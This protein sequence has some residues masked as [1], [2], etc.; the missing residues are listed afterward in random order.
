MAFCTKCGAQNVEGAVHCS[1][2]G[3][4]I[5]GVVAPPQTA[6]APAAPAAPQVTYAPAV[7]AVPVAPNFFA[8][9]WA[10]LD[11]GAKIAGVGAIVTVISFFLPIYEGINGVNVANGMGGGDG[12]ASW[13]FR[14]LLPL[15]ALGLL[16]FYYNNDLRTKIIVAAGHCIIGSLWGFAIF[17]VALGGEYTASAQFG[18]YALHFGFLAIVIGGFMSILDLTRR[19]A[20][21]R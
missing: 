14:F 17:R 18:W 10:S 11:L 9:L 8:V 19:L 15:V 6:N 2:C 12:D 21:V 16:Y 5:P 3:A 13:W 7:P 20:G 4:Q 1:G